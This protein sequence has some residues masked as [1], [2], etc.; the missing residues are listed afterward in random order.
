MTLTLAFK[1]SLIWLLLM[2]VAIVNGVLREQILVPALGMNVALPV[3]GISLSVLV[4]VVS[5]FSLPWFGQH[6]ASTFLFV[7]LQ[8]LLI[9]LIFEFV[10]GHYVVGKSWHD[11]I[12]VFNVTSGDLFLL[13]LL[14]SLFGPYLAARLRGLLS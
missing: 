12:Q 3:S 14:V 6:A 11:L 9:T 8:W 5:Y 13:V 4:L 7:G 1:A 2:L 10:F